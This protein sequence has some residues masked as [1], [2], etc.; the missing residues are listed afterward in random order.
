LPTLAPCK[1]HA[2]WQPKP[3]RARASD[4]A[5]YSP[6]SACYPTWP[7]R[8]WLWRRTLNL[9]PLGKPTHWDLPV[10]DVHGGEVGEVTT[11]ERCCM[12]PSHTAGNGPADLSE[13][14]RWR[15]NVK[16]IRVWSPSRSALLLSTPRL[17]ASAMI[18]AR[19]NG[20][21]RVD[22][23][24]TLQYIM[25]HSNSHT[26]KFASRSPHDAEGPPP[27]KRKYLST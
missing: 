27:K 7:P 6:A 21:I 20:L 1:S 26:P 19:P 23:R 13:G 12:P 17:P 9:L 16:S 8:P 24:K 11:G 18:F 5:I 14:A 22:K 2:S 10:L 15:P 4:P 25:M 3:C